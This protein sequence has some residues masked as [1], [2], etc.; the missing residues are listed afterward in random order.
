MVRATVART[1]PGPR[2]PG[3]CDFR[4]HEPSPAPHPTPSRPRPARSM[5]TAVHR[6]MVD[7]YNRNLYDLEAHRDALAAAAQ[8]IKTQ[9]MLTGKP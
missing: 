7:A 5:R 2:Q 1:S 6:I 4:P 8:R 9:E 3:P